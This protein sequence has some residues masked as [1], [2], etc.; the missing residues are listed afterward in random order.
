[1][2]NTKIDNTK[3]F[4]DYEKLAKSLPNSLA[5]YK[6]PPFVY[7][8]DYQAFNSILLEQKEVKKNLLFGDKSEDFIKVVVVWY[9]DLPG[10]TPKVF[11]NALGEEF[12]GVIII[13]FIEN[14]KEYKV[15][16]DLGAKKIDYVDIFP[17]EKNLCKD[18]VSKYGSL[19]LSKLQRGD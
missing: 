4:L 3:D 10:I 16:V 8:I 6:E 17:E 19:L 9:S 14:Y 2:I 18:Y 1:M 12:K 15:L 5:V 7:L 11:Y 13:P